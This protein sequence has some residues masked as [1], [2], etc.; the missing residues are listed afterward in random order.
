MIRRNYFMEI[1][2]ILYKRHKVNE[3]FDHPRYKDRKMTDEEM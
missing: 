2:N 1:K 3:L